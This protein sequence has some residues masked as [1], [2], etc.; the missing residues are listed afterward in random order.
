MIVG[1]V[2]FF[3]PIIFSGIF[4]YY[5]LEATYSIMQAPPTAGEHMIYL[6]S[7]D[8]LSSHVVTCL[9]QTKRV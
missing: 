6:R 3:F 2:L 8:W 5:D 4:D 9:I 7:H 1:A